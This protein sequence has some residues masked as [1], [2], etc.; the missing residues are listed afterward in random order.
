MPR[1]I[2]F[3]VPTGVGVPSADDVGKQML[4]KCHPWLHDVVLG[5]LK[6]PFPTHQLYQ[7]VINDDIDLDQVI[8]A[9][10]VLGA[11]PFP[12]GQPLFQ[13]PPEEGK[14]T[15]MIKDALVEMRHVTE[16]ITRHLDTA[17]GMIRQER[18]RQIELGWT[19]EHDDEHGNMEL[20]QAAICYMHRAKNIVG[21]AK[22]LPATW[23]WGPILYVDPAVAA[24]SEGEGSD[25]EIV[26]ED[27]PV[28]DIEE[29]ADIKSQDAPQ[30]L[31][32]TIGLVPKRWPWSQDA[33]KPKDRTRDL[34]RAGALGLAASERAG[35]RNLRG[36]Q[37][38]ADFMVRLAVRE[39]A[40][41]L[42][43]GRTSG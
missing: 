26:D 1:S 22:K 29:A 11:V 28:E 6:E 23:P 21:P 33:W 27:A 18:Q 17:L 38:E 7:A 43:L 16:A 13:S 9:I 36:Y 8:K 20:M 10:S 32:E 25:P 31:E 42:Y 24:V 4:A 12:G 19:P 5:E 37:A 39:I 41:D 35:R 2:S 14:P 3:I 30:S 34:I 15:I 40:C